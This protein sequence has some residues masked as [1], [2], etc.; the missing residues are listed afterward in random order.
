MSPLLRLQCAF[1]STRR[2]FNVQEMNHYH[3]P[4]MSHG[5][6]FSNPKISG[7]PTNDRA[8]HIRHW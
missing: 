2:I 4:N 8:S 5:Q 6:A 7:L 1:S 3:P